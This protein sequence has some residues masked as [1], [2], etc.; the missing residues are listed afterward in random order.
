MDFTTPQSLL[1]GGFALAALAAFWRQAKA[2]AWR[3]VNLVFARATFESPGISTAVERYLWR[4]GRR[5]PS[6]SRSFIATYAYVRGRRRH[7]NVPYEMVGRETAVFWPRDG[8][9][10]L[11][12]LFG[13][14]GGSQ[15]NGP[16][17]GA[18]ASENDFSNAS[19]LI[20]IRGTL[21]VERLIIA[22]L[23]EARTPDGPGR[24]TVR[25]V[26]G[27]LGDSRE[28]GYATQAPDRVKSVDTSS[29]YDVKHRAR[30][31]GYR[32]DDIGEP[33]PRDPLTGLVLSETTAT[34]IEDA[35]RWMA[36]KDWYA[37]RG[38]PWR[39]GWMLAGSPGNGK[40]L[41][42]RTVAQLLDLPVWAFDL[43]SMTNREFA[44]YFDKA[45][46]DAPGLVLLEDFDAVF[47]GRKN[48]THAD[49]VGLTFD[50]VL[51]TIGGIKDA[52]GVILVVTTNR[53]EMIDPALGVPAHFGDAGGMSSRPGRLDL[54][55]ELKNP[56]AEERV[57]LARLVFRDDR[58]VTEL[59]ARGA[60]DT[61]A[62]FRERCTRIALEEFWKDRGSV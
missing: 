29:D 7:E 41:I 56:T 34:L 31:I 32:P 17:A 9:W 1:T 18:G 27:A 25:S 14:G 36:A 51:N 8:R 2:L 6:G 13:R 54:A 37:E 23:D 47:E 49:G 30:L 38:I 42:V 57:A 24:F 22:A 26:Y 21:D 35:R 5:L 20:Y 40:T 28:R 3:A 11:P 4:Y 10:R 55:F 60:E 53:P 61:F 39:R 15:F 52:S 19:T 16:T 12:L 45:L 43:A 62:Q 44:D 46:A 33:N 59:V 58:D 50:C 48:V